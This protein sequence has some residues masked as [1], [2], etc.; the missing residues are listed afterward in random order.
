MSV[1][2]THEPM[3]TLAIEGIVSVDEFGLLG[4]GV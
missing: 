2:S 4:Y 3:V 1:L